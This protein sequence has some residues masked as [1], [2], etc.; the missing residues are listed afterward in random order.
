MHHGRLAMHQ[1]ACSHHF[2]AEHFHQRLVTEAHTENRNDAGKLLDHAHRDAGLARRARPRRDAQVRGLELA[3]GCR[4]DLVI[5]IHQHVGA[6]HHERLYEVVGER[7]VVIDQQQARNART[8]DVHSPSSA[9]ASARRR[10]A[11]L[12]RTSWYSAAGELSATMPAPA[13]KLYVSPRN[14]MVRIVIA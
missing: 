10:I 4:R 8:D 5:A 13:W 7:V 2:A 12:A 14:T 9:V 1:P 3:R 11:L 6:E